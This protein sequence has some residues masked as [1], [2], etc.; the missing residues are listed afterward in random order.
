[1]MKSQKTILLLIFFRSLLP[2]YGQTP[3][4]GTETEVMFSVNDT[5]RFGKLN[6]SIVI[7]F[8]HINDLSLPN[9]YPIKAFH[10]FMSDFQGTS[11]EPK[12]TYKEVGSGFYLKNDSLTYGFIKLY[13]PQDSLV[14]G[15]YISLNLELPAT[16]YTSVFHELAAKSILF[17]DIKR[18]Q[19]YDQYRVLFHDSKELEDSIYQVLLN[20]LHSTY[21]MLDEQKNYE[22]VWYKKMES[23]KY[24]G[25]TPM[26]VLK[27]VT[28]ADLESF[29]WY[30]ISYWV[31]YSAQDYHIASSFVGWLSSNSPYSFLEIKNV[32]Y[33]IYENK[34]LFREKLAIFKEAIVNENAVK[35]LVTEVISLTNAGNHT[36][37]GKLADFIIELAREA[38]DMDGLPWGYLIRAQVNQELFDY[39]GANRLCDSAIRYALLSGDKEA[40]VKSSVKKGYCLYASLQYNEA[41][42][43][44]QSVLKKIRQYRNQLAAD[45]YSP[46]ASRVFEY[47]STIYKLRGDYLTSMALLDSAISINKLFYSLE[48]QLKNADFFK[49]KGDILDKQ[50]KPKDA[51]NEYNAALE[52]YWN[53]IKVQDWAKTLNE[54]AN[55][56]FSLGEYRKSIDEAAR[57]AERLLRKND[58]DN[59]GYSYSI[60][61]QS[62]WNL[63]NFDS[64]LISHQQ[65]IG[66]KRKGNNISGI[67]WSWLQ[68]GELYG[69]SGQK[70]LAL[71]AYDSSAF[72]YDSVADSAGL[73]DVFNKKGIVYLNDENYK[74]AIR[75]FESARG[76]TSKTTVDGL[77]N[78]GRAWNEVDPVKSR[79]YYEQSRSLSI[80]TGN[81]GM[82][83]SSSLNLGYLAY[84][85]SNNGDGDRY[86]NE[87]LLLSNEIQT[88]ET[89]AFCIAL[90]GYKAE[91]N[92]EPDSALN[93]YTM[94]VSIFSRVNRI[95]EVYTLIS[96]TNVLIS[97]GEFKQA[98]Q[99]ISRAIH[100]ADDASI[101]LELGEALA[102]SS[103]LYGR[104]GEF[105]KGL[106]N[107]DSAVRIFRNSGFYIRLGN[108]FIS[109]GSL[110]SS[111]GQYRNAIET[112]LT[113]DSIFK[114][115]L[116][117]EYRSTVYNNIGVVYT[118]Q[119]DYAAALKNLDISLSLLPKGAVNENYLLIQGNRAECLYF[120]KQIPEAEKLLL[121][122]LP[123]ARQQQLHRIATGMAITLGTLY[124]KEGN[125]EKAIPYFVYARDYGN[126]SGE[127]EKSI[128]ALRY[129]AQI[130]TGNNKPDEAEKMLRQSI[131][132]VERFRTGIGWESY[133][134]LGLLFSDRHQPDSAEKYFKGAI[135]LLE[136]NMENLY[137]G[138]EARKL[139]D[140]DPR[141]ADLYNKI[142][143]LLFDLGKTDE[144][145]AYAN[146]YNLAGI[147]ELS[148]SLT[149]NSSSSEKNEALK[150][151]FAMQ[152][153]QKLLREAARKQEGDA[154]S[155]TLKKI[156]ILEKDYNN[157]LQDMVLKYDDLE[158]YFSRTNADEFYNYKSRIPE[159][160]AVLLY[161]QNDKTTMIFSLTRESLV[162]DTMTADPGDLVNAFIASIKDTRTVTG[163]GSL[164]ARSEP[165]D[166]ESSYSGTGFRELSARLY[167]ILIGSVADKISSKKKIC[168][169]P[170]GIFSNLPFQCLG[171]NTAQNGFRFLIEDYLV[172]YT[173]KMSVFKEGAA[174]PADAAPFASFAAF[175]VP[176]P[177]LR[178]NIE[179]VKT[180][181]KILGSDST[182][183]A[184]ER[185]TESMAKMSLLHKKIIH[186]ATH[187]VLNYSSD[188]SQSYLKL[189]PDKDTSDGN[190][191]KLT[192]R[193][194]QRIGIRDCN[195]VILSACQ[196]AVSAELVRGWSIS[197]ANS[198]LIS[199]VKSVVASYWKVADEPTSLL[200]EYFYQNLQTMGKAEALREAQIRLSK[201]PRFVHPNYWGA[202]VLYGDWR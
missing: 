124:Y 140:N 115:E 20:D 82:H 128:E 100:I 102:T 186:F 56:Y 25:L 130:S 45:V 86:Y 35:S 58:Y 132:L 170:T 81:T 134:E 178:Y 193:E 96:A 161:M 169:I 159:D 119:E 158:T 185:A 126:S 43:Y 172:F 180:L 88:E 135:E 136:K 70:T 156:E 165:V 36:Q 67:A 104:T 103:F 150:K 144:A 184:D 3:D 174:V 105:S 149:L 39:A 59:A 143:F 72:Y 2:L 162:V 201:D 182:V 7:L 80:T 52:V 11:P 66:Y 109:R 106:A 147:K 54:I 118:G 69:L 24:R 117:N 22:G 23:G 83:F 191:G 176:D 171:R 112:Y 99:V 167:E 29:I 145:W 131:T 30:A 26:D 63:G 91:M 141:K 84:K 37:A 175:G 44:L 152:Q 42:E 8:N 142:T 50:G 10:F 33:P 77:Y 160:L 1:M 61:G 14:K 127:V 9:G 148:G 155:E 90:N 101:Q 200:M 68:M 87:C 133:Y 198:F 187:G 188:Y 98:D 5:Y 163:T 120:L 146:R 197:P 17:T 53:N 60:M 157:F 32:L 113:A 27:N 114:S 13:N 92:I 138:E 6:D 48:A 194:I 85:Y 47:R 51:L 137:G 97:K 110:L 15:D 4:S 173:N 28:R 95:Q 139:F 19:H 12:R 151:L 93:R 89:Q 153:E 123:V 38:G 65:A 79:N 57:A 129:L 108:T 31:G 34:A 122:V 75:L 183:Y 121:D 18:E 164:A 202:F 78:L 55:T 73:G 190:N 41:D 40:E 192:M 168:F 107:S 94:A 46:Q 16:N 74:E 125:P 199:N 71:S 49:L 181:G 62:F 196:T 116:V 154:R 166:E 21:K 195:M 189:L 179:E 64:A 177:T 76:I 111:M